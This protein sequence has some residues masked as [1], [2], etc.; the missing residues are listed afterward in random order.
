MDSLY[1]KVLIPSSIAHPHISNLVVLYI[2]FYICIFKG[3]KSEVF[4]KV[5]LFKVFPGLPG[6]IVKGFTYMVLFFKDCLACLEILDL[7][8]QTLRLCP[9][10][11]ERKETPVQRENQAGMDWPEREVGH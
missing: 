4:F 7:C 8:L 6:D 5:K 2:Y 3:F 10:R 1:L 9:G 11:K